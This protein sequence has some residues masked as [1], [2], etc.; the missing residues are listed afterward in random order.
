MVWSEE[1][2]GNSSQPAMGFGSLFFQTAEVRSPK[3][4]ISRVDWMRGLYITYKA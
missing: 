4:V 1:I 2:R 3:T